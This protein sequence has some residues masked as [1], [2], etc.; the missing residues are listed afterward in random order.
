[1]NLTLPLISAFLFALSI[2]LSKIFLKDLNPSFTAGLFYLSSAGGLLIYKLFTDSNEAPVNKKD[3]LNISIIMLSGGILAPLFLF[4]AI[5]VSQA[6]TVSLLLNTE[7]ILTS[8]IAAIFFKEHTDKYFWSGA[9]LIVLGV[10]ILSLKDGN[11]FILSQG[12]IL[13]LFAC[14]MWSIDNNFTAILSSKN[15]YSVTIIKGLIGG[16]AN[17]TISILTE[18]PKSIPFISFTGAF[19]TGIFSYGASLVLLIYSM[20]RMGAARSIALFGA[21]PFIS[22][23]L[24]IFILKEK[25]ELSNTLAF[26]LTGIGVYSIFSRKHIHI[27]KHLPYTHEHLHSHNDGHHN[28]SHNTENA[29]LKHSHIHS[30]EYI[31]HEHE[32]L[33]DIHH[34][35]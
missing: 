22:F 34:K 26:I 2:P 12:S 3:Y 8:L 29:D 18:K 1:M 28:H 24:S 6:A 13:A 20:R 17:I 25:I 35:H 32:H 5:A 33:P 27:H 15:P 31:E 21:Y 4:K 10:S 30:H 16:I 7:I 19:L 14:L 23:F 11:I 9:I